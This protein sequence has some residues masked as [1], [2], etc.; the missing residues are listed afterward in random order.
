MGAEV[1]LISV[2]DDLVT[3]EGTDGIGGCILVPLNVYG[4]LKKQIFS[5]FILKVLST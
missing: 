4:N 1:Q 5:L 2:M 3:P